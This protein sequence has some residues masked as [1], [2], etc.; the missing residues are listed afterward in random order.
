[1]SLNLTT[2]IPS[3]IASAHRQS[4]TSLLE[5]LVSI[6]LMSFGILAMAGMQAY[7]VAAQR[8]AANRGIASMLA[9]EY[10]EIIRLNQDGFKAGSYDVARLT[11]V[12]PPAVVA[13]AFPSCSTA[14]TL[15][16]AD[17]TAF[18]NLVRT[19]LPLGG[20]ELSRPTIAG[21]KSNT[22]ADLWIVWEE[23][24]VLNVTKEGTA[25]STELQV[26][27]CPADAKALAQ[28]P[29]CFYMKVQL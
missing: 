1:M 26:D 8:N 7:S 23:P 17:L 28:L 13:C 2:A 25:A 11:D 21:V 24:Q 15:A 27:N 4:G 5:V 19:Q 10:A 6:L 18:Q 29:R 16:T 9:N 20:V 3:R 22:E 12:D 14:A